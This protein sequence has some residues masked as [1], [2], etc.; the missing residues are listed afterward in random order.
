MTAATTLPAPIDWHQPDEP[1]D[2]PAT[3]AAGPYLGR[4]AALADIT[5][6][7]F[8]LSS[9]TADEIVAAVYDGST[10]DLTL[11][12]V[13]QLIVDRHL[14]VNSTADVHAVVRFIAQDPT[15]FADPESDPAL[16]A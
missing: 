6:E 5:A 9:D 12:A 8:G 13:E 3:P 14:L 11:A 2:D 15:L 7:E 1:A 10:D 16:A 4:L